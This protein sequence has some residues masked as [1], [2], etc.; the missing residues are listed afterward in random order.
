MYKH[1]QSCELRPPI[2]IIGKLEL[3]HSYT[4]T[5][6]YRVYHVNRCGHHKKLS[7]AQLDFA[8]VFGLSLNFY[9]T[10][11]RKLVVLT[12]VEL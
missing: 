5:H 2:P 12:Y 4:F 8:Q 6:R 10:T 7:I 1:T 11:L 9:N 3:S